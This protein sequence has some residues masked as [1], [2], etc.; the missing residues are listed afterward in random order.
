MDIYMIVK[1]RRTNKFI[2]DD[3]ITAICMNHLSHNSLWNDC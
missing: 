2:D 3:K 1:K